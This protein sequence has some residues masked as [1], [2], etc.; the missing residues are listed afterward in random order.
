M[1]KFGRGFVNAATNPAFLGGMMDAFGKI[2]ATPRRRREA[3]EQERMAQGLF[4][5]E[6]AVK[7][8]KVS[9]ELYQTMRSA[10]GG[11][12]TP[13][14]E[15]YVR[16]R[17]DDIQEQ[18]SFNSK[19]EISSIREQM[20]AVVNSNLPDP[21]KRAQLRDLQEKANQAAQMGRVDPMA[22]GQLTRDVQ[23]DVFTQQQKADQ[24]QRIAEDHKVNMEKATYVLEKME[25]YRSRGWLRDLDAQVKG[26]QLKEADMRT[27]LKD[28]GVSREVAKK[29]YGAAGEAMWDT[30]DLERK[31]HE[32]RVLDA[33][34]KK[35]TGEF[36]YT[37]E[38]LIS[39]GFTQEQ[40]KFLRNSPPASAHSA[41]IAKIKTPVNTNN[42]SA[43][44]QS[45]I[46]K[47]IEHRIM[48]AYGLNYKRSADVAKG[49][50]LAAQQAQDIAKYWTGDIG[51]TLEA[52]TAN[53]GEVGVK[54]EDQ[55]PQRG[56]SNTPL[57][58]EEQVDEIAASLV[59]NQ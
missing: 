41:V 40:L 1:A 7:A 28:T 22:V 24:A 56:T 35:K 8:G 25:E 6:E 19:A 29:R 18:A 45:N 59:Q 13:K 43:A 46:A 54:F 26:A 37:D 10:Y 3:E 23:K 34:N 50:A 9:P 32:V 2:G 39:I 14:N 11:K 17:L 48:T 42:L 58:L 20:Y 49:K 53:V 51:T 4:G 57:T 15:K 47:A 30:L 16:G 44:A 52:Y 36:N 33:E 5:M 31:E 55:T 38:E 21:E 12:I 27:F